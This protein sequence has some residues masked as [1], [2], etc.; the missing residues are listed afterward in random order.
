MD[1]KKI[2]IT[3]EGELRIKVGR[4][5]GLDEAV[6]C[7]RECQTH[8]GQ[9][10]RRVVFDLVGTQSIQTAGLGFMMMVKE[11]CNTTKE[12]TV[13]LYDHPQIGQMLFLAHF[14]E[15]FQLVRQGIGETEK[16]REGKSR[17]DGSAET[18]A[19]GE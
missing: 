13:I 11:R 2:S 17:A 15:K 7:M 12:D 14:E 19:Q 10:S 3:P 18:A 1:A 9:P 8:S 16:M 5:F 4:H 6:L